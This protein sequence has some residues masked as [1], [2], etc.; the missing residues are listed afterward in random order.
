MKNKTFLSVILLV[1]PFF[2]C[3]QSDF[4]F[5]GEIRVRTELD[6]RDFLNS[7]YPQSFTALR[8]RLGLEKKLNDHVSIFIQLQDSR[9]FGEEKHT[10]TSL[11]NIDLHQ[12]FATI[13]DIFDI[14]LFF[15][16]GRFK[17]IYG[18][19]KI[20]G[21]NEW[22]NVGRS[23]DGFILGY[24]TEKHKTDLFLTTHTN[25]MNYRAGAA[26]VFENYNYT[27]A[28]PDTGFNIFGFYSTHKLAKP[29]S[30]EFYAY[31]EW[32]RYR[33][34]SKDMQLNRYTLG[35]AMEFSPSTFPLSFRVEA[36]YQGGK[37]F[38]SK[39]QDISSLM[40]FA[41]LQYKF[42]DFSISLNADIN[43][44]A[45]TTK[46]NKY[47]LF[48]NPFASK[49]N[50]QGY[51]DFFTGLSEP[52]FTT[53]IYGLNDFFLRITYVPSKIF[54]AQLDLHYFT[55]FEKLTTEGHE[56]YKYGPEANLVLKYKLYEAV[57]FEWGSAV[58]Y[59]DEV[60]KKLYK[61]LSKRGTIDKFDPAFWTYLQINLKF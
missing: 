22:H 34:N 47:K 16:F 57:E 37:I 26:R 1:L 10:L 48:D 41:T 30:N 51:M 20:F 3:A 5:S 21:P 23:H 18:N 50:F 25:F 4:K 56:K 59:P 31:Y 40:L 52:R 55:T 49:H 24:N 13:K 9:V 15:K 14:P 8:T 36:A 6:G 28:P 38:T 11:K 2:L 35:T 45:D 60:M 7:T 29:I 46:T 27:E 61:D 39:L 19:Y 33:P 43:S 42:D 58:F 17:L 12:G 44:G 53:G 54:N 32:N